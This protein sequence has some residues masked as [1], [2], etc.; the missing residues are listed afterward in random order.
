[1]YRDRSLL[2][3]ALGR[4][5]HAVLPRGTLFQL[6]YGTHTDTRTVQ[7]FAQGVIVCVTVTA[8]AFV[9]S[10]SFVRFEVSVYYGRPLSVSGR[11]CY[12]FII[13]MYHQRSVLLS[14]SRNI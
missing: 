5:V 10:L 6:G 1:M 12:I 3:W 9:S 14:E 13:I 4:S 2:P 8:R 7:V 11:P